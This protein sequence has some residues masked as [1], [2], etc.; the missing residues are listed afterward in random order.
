[1]LKPRYCLKEQCCFRWDQ[2]DIDFIV[3]AEDPIPQQTK[4]ELLKVLERIHPNAPEKGLEMSV[5][6]RTY[7]EKFVHPTPYELHF[8]NEWRLVNY[9]ENPLSLNSYSSVT[10]YDL[11]AH[12]TVIKTVGQVVIGKPV[13]EVFGCIPRAEYLDS[14]CRDIKEA[15]ADVANNPVYVILNLCR[16]YAYIRDTAILSKEQGAKWG[17]K[18]LPAQYHNLISNMLNRYTGD[19]MTIDNQELQSEFCEYMLEQ[20]FREA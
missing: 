19:I 1:M 9:L 15:K 4:I 5:V 12:F 17:L 7:C 10:D 20:I 16:V 8:S 3:V 2:S 14:I 18:N 6:L 13:A 11:A